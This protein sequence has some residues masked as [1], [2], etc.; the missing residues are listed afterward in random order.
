MWCTL[1]LCCYGSQR[2]HVGIWHILAAQKGSHTPAFRPNYIP[3]SYMDPLGLLVYA[4]VR[5]QASASG[6]L[7]RSCGGGGE[8]GGSVAE[9]HFIGG[10]MVHKIEYGAA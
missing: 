1:G 7:V 10:T 9:W 5:I 6:K 3:Y 4:V 2:V 8:G